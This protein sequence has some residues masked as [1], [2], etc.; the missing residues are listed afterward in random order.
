MI[1]FASKKELASL[2]QSYAKLSERLYQAEDKLYTLRQAILLPETGHFADTIP[3]KQA[4]QLLIDELG[5][6]LVEDATNPIKL[7]KKV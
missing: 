2:Q 5:Y 7:V 3:L 4:V 1:F 6:T